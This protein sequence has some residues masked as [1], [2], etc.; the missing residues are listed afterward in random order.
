MSHL[1]PGDARHWP[2][3]TGPEAGEAVLGAVGRVPGKM[4]VEAGPRGTTTVVFTAER[5]REALR[6]ASGAKEA[7]LAVRLVP[8]GLDLHR[9]AVVH[10]LWSLYEL[11]RL[12][13]RECPWDRKQTQ[14]DIVAYTLEETYEL[15]DTVRS[16]ERGQAGQSAR[17][18]GGLALPGL[19]LGLRGRAAR[20]V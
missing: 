18:T 8:D 14:E 13:R 15:V 6:L 11:T 4:G 17:R 3:L 12:L 19:F 9:E 1:G 20:L 5:A 16:S 10:E 7:G 2:R